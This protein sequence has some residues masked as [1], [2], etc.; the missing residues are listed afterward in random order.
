MMVTQLPK[1]VLGLRPLP[2][3]YNYLRIR[4][5]NECVKALGALKWINDPSLS[6]LNVYK[7]TNRGA[8]CKYG[9]GGGGE[10][11]FILCFTSHGTIFQLYM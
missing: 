7:L 10:C 4:E 9:G 8:I 2:F 11:E 3:Q 1:S 6:S 5:Y